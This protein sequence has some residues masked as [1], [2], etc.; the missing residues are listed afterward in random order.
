MNYYDESVEGSKERFEKCI[1]RLKSKG[2]SEDEALFIIGDHLENNGQLE[3]NEVKQCIEYIASHPVYSDDPKRAGEQVGTIGVNGVAKKFQE[4]FNKYKEYDRIKHFINK[5][6]LYKKGFSLQGRGSLSNSF[7]S[8]F[9]GFSGFG[10]SNLIRNL[11]GKNEEFRMSRDVEEEVKRETVQSIGKLDFFKERFLPWILAAQ[12]NVMKNHKWQIFY[13]TCNLVTNTNSGVQRPIL[14]TNLSMFIYSDPNSYIIK[15]GVE[16]DR[17][18]LKNILFLTIIT[19]KMLLQGK[20]SQKGTYNEILNY[21]DVNKLKNPIII[22]T[23]KSKM[24]KCKKINGE[25]ECDQRQWAE[26]WSIFSDS[27]IN[28]AVR[29]ILDID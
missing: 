21:M 6:E 18:R 16:K 2:Y 14:L 9:G 11:S 27:Q 24:S 5:E 19:H 10:G 22:G 15:K 29:K 25:V 8:G 7:G 23:I 3:K 1:E 20:N 26:I 4:K 28:K 17:G 13:E 12:T